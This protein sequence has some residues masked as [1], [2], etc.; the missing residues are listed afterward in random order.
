MPSECWKHKILH[1]VKWTP[2][3]IISVLQ[4]VDKQSLV[5]IFKEL[6]RALIKVCIQMFICCMLPVTVT[7]VSL[8]HLCIILRIMPV[9]LKIQK[10]N[11]D[12]WMW[13]TSRRV[14]RYFIL[15]LIFTPLLTSNPPAEISC[16]NTGLSVNGCG[17]ESSQPYSLW[18]KIMS[19][20]SF[21]SK[22]VGSNWQQTS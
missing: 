7:F 9:T 12:S 8:I 4:S 13:N 15:V 11:F 20:T 17:F 5:A 6:S 10:I 14:M 3:H 1:V 22:K 18:Q 21:V 16:N 2:L 19:F